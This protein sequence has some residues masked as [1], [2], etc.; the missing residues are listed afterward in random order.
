MVNSPTVQIQVDWTTRSGRS[1]GL[2]DLA[3]DL[4]LE[5]N[6]Q[7]VGILH[8]ENGN[9]SILSGD[10][11]TALVAVD[12]QRTLLGVLGGTTH[13]FVANLQG[14]LRIEGDRALALRVLLGL[15]SG[16][17]WSDLARS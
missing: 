8:V 6:C 16:S 15:R 12:C 9:V 13:P 11:A 10:D 2:S 3:G 4:R 7:P 14:R 17:P 5:I 1:S